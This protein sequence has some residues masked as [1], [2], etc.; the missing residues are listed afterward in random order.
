V[1]VI[2]FYGLPLDYLDTYIAS[3]E[4]VTLEDIRDAFARRIR[5]EAMITVIAGPQDA[6]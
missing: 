4:S 5:P 1:A 6:S 2:G 3:V